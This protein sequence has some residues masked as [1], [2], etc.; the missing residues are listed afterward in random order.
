MRTATFA[1]CLTAVLGLPRP[2]A[3][4][5]M[6]RRLERQVERFIGRL[7]DGGQVRSDERTAWLVYDIAADRKLITI[8]EDEPLQSAS[9]VKPIIAL[10]FFDAVKDG[11]LR[12]GARERARL[13][14]M[15]RDSDNA[16]AN[17][18]LRRLGGPAAAQARLMR[19]YGGLLSGLRLVEYIPADGR[20]YGNRASAHD[21][22]RFLYALWRG[23]LPGASEIKRAMGLPNRD[24][25]TDGVAAVP[26]DVAVYDKTGTT[27]RLCG[28]MG[29]LVARAAN[30]RAYPYIFVGVIQKE[31]HARHY[32]EWMRRRGDVIRGVSALAYRAMAA[33]HG[34]DDGGGDAQP[35]GSGS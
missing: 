5:P 28:D 29:I 23:S 6:A 13:E 31:S 27:A 9:L 35:P 2:A 15:I 17:W 19:R 12:Y 21:Y 22:S 34:L 10:A 16:A 8:N 24:R 30:G 32:F 14:A 3:A 33:R 7:R 11:R 20:T 26:D 25:L 18:F 1:F 4:E